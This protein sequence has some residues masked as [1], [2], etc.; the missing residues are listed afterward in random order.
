MPIS[1]TL[2]KQILDLDKESRVE[3]TIKLLESLE[4]EPDHNAFNDWVEEAEGRYQAWKRGEV[5][6]ISLEEAM[7]HLKHKR[8]K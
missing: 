5:K 6:T 8:Q 7:R 2:Q 4:E 1:H 3:L